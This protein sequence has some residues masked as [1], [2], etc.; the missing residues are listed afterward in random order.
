MGWQ[1]IESAE[2]SRPEGD[3]VEIEIVKTK[4]S[5]KNKMNKLFRIFDSSLLW[6]F[7]S[8]RSDSDYAALVLRSWK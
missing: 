8:K 1:N 4:E 7:L 5:T 2:M 6:G 3:P